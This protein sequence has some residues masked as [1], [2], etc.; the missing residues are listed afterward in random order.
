VIL[1]APVWK[2]A[3]DPLPTLCSIDGSMA[4]V[5]T[6]ADRKPILFPVVLPASWSGLAAQLGGRGMNGMIPPLTMSFGMTTGQ[7]LLAGGFATTGAT[8]DTPTAFP[9]GHAAMV[10]DCRYGLCSTKRSRRRCTLLTR[11][12]QGRW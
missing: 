9:T 11:R 10:V 6:G 5:E 2:P 4:P 3:A 1:N 7:L 12:K 8:R